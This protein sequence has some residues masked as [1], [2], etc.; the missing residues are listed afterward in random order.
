VVEESEL[1]AVPAVRVPILRYSQVD[2][3]DSYKILDIHGRLLALL[4]R[5]AVFLRQLP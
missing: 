4:L 1:D 5:Q 2:L 3:E